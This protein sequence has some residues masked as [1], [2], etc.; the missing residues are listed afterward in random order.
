MSDTSATMASGSLLVDRASVSRSAVGPAGVVG[1]Q[2][3]AAFDHELV[4]VRRGA[5]PC[6]PAFDDVEREEFLG[7]AAL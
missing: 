6:E 3:H 5:Q 4:G 1:G 2:E 7:A